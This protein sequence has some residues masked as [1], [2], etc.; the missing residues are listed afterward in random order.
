MKFVLTIKD[1]KFSFVF[2]LFLF[3]SCS[4]DFLSLD[5][6]F[7][8]PEELAITSL[9]GLSSTTTGAFNA[10]QS[11]NLYGGGLIANSE[12]LADNIHTDPISDFSLNQLR[13]HA[14]NSYNS[15]AGG[16][17]A[18]GYRAINIT[19]IVLENLP[20]YENED[21]E[22]AKQ[23]KGECLFIRAI[24]HFELV[25][26]F[27]QGWGYTSDNS[28]LGIPIRLSSGS[29]TNGQNTSR[30]SVKEVYSQIISDLTQAGDLLTDDIQSRASKWAVEAFLAKVYFQQ[31]DYQNAFLMSDKIINEG[32]FTLNAT[33]DEIYGLEGSSFS[34]ETIFQ[35]INVDGDIS[36]GDLNR[37]NPNVMYSMGDDFI[38]IITG[39]TLTDGTAG[40]RNSEL[41][42]NFFDLAYFTKKY[43]NTQMNV[44]VIRLAEMYLTRAE[45][46]AQL[47]YSDQEVRDDYNVLLVRAGQTADSTT[48]EK[49][50]LLQAIW[51]ER[52]YELAYEG[53]RYHDL[54][55]RKLDFVTEVGTFSWDDRYL[56]YPIPQ[57]E[58]DANPN[59]EQNEGY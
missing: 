32:G 7:K 13:T 36:N 17:W 33:V 57:T 18:D 10:I 45:C 22:L 34:N 20:T 24:C 3:A 9:D 50:N 31:N 28:H 5:P 49:N 14:M 38:S 15:Q 27:S 19:N 2:I 53:D 21:I 46:K 44:P 25:R 23:I 58:I 30:S 26:M 8:F 29:V 47:N 4:K 59:M 6:E 51:N 52:N 1:V 54:K 16:L 43:N 39:D 56:I 35:I 41:Y 40:L 42:T 12:L 11:G 55:R 48:S 37:F